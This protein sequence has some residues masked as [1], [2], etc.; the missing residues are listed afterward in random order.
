MMVLR[1]EMDEDVR[2]GAFGTVVPDWLQVSID[3]RDVRTGIVQG[4]ASG[5]S[6]AQNILDW[7]IVGGDRLHKRGTLT[8]PFALHDIAADHAV[9]LLRIAE[10]KFT[11]GCPEAAMTASIV[12]QGAR[13]ETEFKGLWA[14]AFA[15][16]AT[17]GTKK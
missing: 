4:G 5:G 11:P 8:F 15:K 17:C 10:L 2:S 16:H 6:T 7:E 9:H 3:T 12:K 14:Q 1:D 13:N